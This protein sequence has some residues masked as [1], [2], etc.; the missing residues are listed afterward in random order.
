MGLR[1]LGGPCHEQG[2]QGRLDPPQRTGKPQAENR[3]PQDLPSKPSL[4]VL[5]L[6]LDLRCNSRTSKALLENVMTTSTALARR[7]RFLR[8]EG[9]IQA[10]LTVFIIA[11]SLFVLCAFFVLPAVFTDTSRWKATEGVLVQASRTHLGIR[12]KVRIQYTYQVDGRTYTGRRAALWTDS[13]PNPIVR[14]APDAWRPGTPV[15]VYYQPTHPERAVLDPQVSTPQKAAA[16]F[17]TGLCLLGTIAA[18]LP[19]TRVSSIPR[20]PRRRSG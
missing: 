17:G 6:F 5:P 18:F 16:I 20:Y 1:R 8:T 2:G 15:R 3:N 10:R 9:T 4:L 7:P 12:G 11:G 14:Q 19:G 13:V